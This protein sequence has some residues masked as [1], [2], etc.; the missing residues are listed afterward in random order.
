MS[1]T[2]EFHNNEWHLCSKAG[3]SARHGAAMIYDQKQKLTYLFGG[4]TVDKQYG[5][6]AGETWTWDGK[7]WK[8]VSNPQPL[9]I[10]NAASA[11]NKESG[12]VRFGGWNGD[13]RINET[14]KLK[15]NKWHQLTLEHSPTP[16]NHSNMVF[17]NLQNQFVLFGGHDGTNVFGDTWVFKGNKW[18]LL[19]ECKPR[20]RVANGH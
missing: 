19:H 17:D 15:G 18:I 3:P 10:F 13:G 16:R 14:W 7:L 1:D 9:G 4:S 5:I 20:E 8:K 2:W 12:F 11:Y 6:S